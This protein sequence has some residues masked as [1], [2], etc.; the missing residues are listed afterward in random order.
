M[1]LKRPHLEEPVRKMPVE[2][3]KWEAALSE[4][5]NADQVEVIWRSLERDTAVFLG[6]L[7]R[8]FTKWLE[9]HPGSALNGNEGPTCKLGEVC[10]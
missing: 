6:T 9:E 8:A 2:V 1:V 7:E 10:A 4:F 3:T 5:P